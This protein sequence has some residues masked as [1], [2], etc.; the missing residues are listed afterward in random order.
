M[1]INLLCSSNAVLAADDFVA[2]VIKKN[3]IECHNKEDNQGGLDLTALKY[4]LKDDATFDKWVKIH[5]RVRDGEMPPDDVVP[6]ASRDPFLKQLFT[7]L[8]R[9][10]REKIK[11]TGRAIYRRMNR[12]EY[13]NTIRDL[14]QAPWLQIKDT[15]PEDGEAF[16]FNKVGE[17]LDT[18]YVQI[19]RFMQTA[20]SA[21]H[22]VIASQEKMPAKS[23]TKY[24]AR[25]QGA[26][27][28]KMR[29]QE[30]NRSPERSTF[31]VLGF[32]ADLELLNSGEGT[33]F[34]VGAGNPSK[35]ELEAFAVVASSY[36]PIEIQYNR[37]RAQT[38]GRYKL[39]FNT[40]SVWV[41]PSKN[42]K[43]YW[44]PDRE[45]ISHG[46]RPEPIAIYSVSPP[47]QLRK[48]G[49][50]DAE[51]EPGVDEL[52][53]MLL[54][55]ETIQ[56]DAC[57]LFRS[58]PPGNWHNPL[59]TEEGM[60][61]VAFKWME[62]EGPINDTWPPHGHRVLFGNLPIKNGANKNQVDVIPKNP[63]KDSWSLLKLF[64][65]K[66]CRRKVSEEEFDRYYKVIQTA[67]DSGS[68]FSDAMIA[69]YTTVLCSPAFLFLEEKSNV[70]TQQELA[71]RLS[72][73]IWNSAPDEKLRVMA[74]KG[75]LLK[76]N[77]LQEQTDRLLYDTKSRRFVDGFLD[78]WLDLR[79]VNDTSPDATLY[80]DYYLDD[81]LVESSIEEAQNYFIEIMKSNQPA[82]SIMT[83]DFA[84]LNER[85][86]THYN[87]PNVTGVKFRKV[88][89]PKDSPRG[90]FMT[91][92]SVL[93]ITANGTTTS[94]VTRGAWVMERML[95]MKPPPPPPSIPAV[96]P[97]TRG[98]K[99]IR[100]QLEKH[101]TLDTCNKCHAKIDPVGFA[102]ESFDIFGGYRTQYRALGEGGKHELGYGK[103][104]QPFEFHLAQPI[105]C[106]GVLPGG[107]E[108]KDIF[109]LKEFILLYERQIARNLTQQLIIYG[110]GA[111]IRFSDRAEIELILDKTK[112]SNYGIRNILREIIKSPIFQNK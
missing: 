40:Y 46:H 99:T 69:G 8:T 82:R 51:T 42:A 32:E 78:Y 75:D 76:G 72:Y 50:F 43:R 54:R 90:G 1:G 107:Q 45:N 108:F 52:D 7:D 37:F 93:K 58:R 11:L 27:S 101:R 86:A 89:L 59:A 83:S 34:T 33:P 70:L 60:P 49:D 24:Y 100:E 96:E 5:D 35:R 30:F 73:F 10:D 38:P 9:A 18:S 91:M 77:N 17:A 105:D 111:P 106:A 94:P 68:S 64:V 28:G 57:R 22:Q 4:D 112:S 103:N 79:K 66:A 13:E 97:D 74:E 67:L 88:Q 23:T 110:T 84:M 104:G 44:T 2:P 92:A 98:A 29:F 81:S 48:I 61:G 63:A 12:Y 80:P 56:P 55:N 85:M 3:C 62:V 95:G 109:E 102:L 21:L 20:D 36:E 6:K 41:G 25:E 87:I 26:F 14:L 65:S 47:R 39:R 16:R 71:T 19:S 15:L 53:V 31:P